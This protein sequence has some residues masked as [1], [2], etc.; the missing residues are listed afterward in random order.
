VDEY[1]RESFKDA[2]ID[3]I[4][5]VFRHLNWGGKKSPLPRSIR[6]I[7]APGGHLYYWGDLPRYKLEEG[8]VES[9]QIRY[10]ETYYCRGSRTWLHFSDL[11]LFEI[12]LNAEPNE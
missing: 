5:R 11:L 8:P 3:Y 10:A 9:I 4:K 6:W 12:D 7:K 1:H 2:H